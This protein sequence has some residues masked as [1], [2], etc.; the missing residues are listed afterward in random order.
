MP[1]VVGA[2]YVVGSPPA[3]PVLRPLKQPLYDTEIYPAA[4][5]GRLQF[6]VN[7]STIAATGAAKT[8][9]DTNMTQNGQLGTPLEFD[10]IGFNFEPARRTDVAAVTDLDLIMNT[11]VWTWIFG[12]NTP[13]LQVPITRIPEGVGISGFAATTV[14]ATTIIGASNGTPHVT[15]FYNFAVDRRARH[16]FSTESFRGELSYPIG[17][18]PI[19]LATRVRA[20]MLGILFAQL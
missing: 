20:Y 13:W 17:V 5:V 10:L 19:T 18:V 9:A 7:S 6:F 15:N 14:A 11:G 2:Q 8:L 1:R 16:I 3:T 12:Q 4:G